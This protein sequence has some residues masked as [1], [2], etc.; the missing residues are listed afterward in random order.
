MRSKLSEFIPLVALAATVVLMAAAA[1]G[2]NECRRVG[3]WSGSGS[4][5]TDHGVGRASLPT[6]HTGAV[7]Q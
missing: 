3:R 4:G 1:C 5:H 7:C 2:G 6:R